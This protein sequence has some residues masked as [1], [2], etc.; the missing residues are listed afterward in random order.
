M[1]VTGIT[2]ECGGGGGGFVLSIVDVGVLRGSQERVWLRT[3]KLCL[4]V[5]SAASHRSYWLRECSR[6]MNG[7][8]VAVPYQLAR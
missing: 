1:A 3:V 7:G 4:G 5:G 2:A 8:T 6:N